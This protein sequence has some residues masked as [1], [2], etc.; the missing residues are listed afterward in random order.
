MAMSDEDHDRMMRLIALEMGIP[1]RLLGEPGRAS[2]FDN[3]RQ[4]VRE[5]HRGERGP[6]GEV[7]HRRTLDMP[8]DDEV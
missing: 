2:N 6:R 8:M 5:W 4:E 7:P 1:G 3:Y